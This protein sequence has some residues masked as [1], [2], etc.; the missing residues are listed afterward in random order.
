MDRSILK[1]KLFFIF[2]FLFGI[3]SFTQNQISLEKCDE[4]FLKNNLF[5]LAEQFN[6]SASKAEIIQA[7]IWDLPVITGELNAYNPQ[8]KQYFDVN[9]NGQKAFAIQ[10]LIYLGGKKRNE[11]DFA[12]S[13]SE[14]A[15]LQ[16]EQLLRNLKYQLHQSFYSIY[17]DISKTERINVQLTNLDSL[18]S[19]YTVQSEKGNIPLKDLVR[20]ESLALSFK[21]VIIDIQNNIFLEQEKLRILTNLGENIEPKLDEDKINSMLLKNIIQNENELKEISLAK[22]PDYLTSLKIIENG[23]LYVKWQKSL[24]IPDLTMGASYD[25]RGGAFVNQVNVTF[26]IP[27]PLWRKNKGNVLQATA[28]LEESK[29]LKDQSALEL[30]TKISTA[31]SSYKYEQVKYIEMLN[32]MKQFEVVYIGIL[33]NFQKRNISL[34]EFTDFMES[35]NSSIVIINEIKNHIILTGEKI[36]YLTNE[37]IF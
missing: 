8:G 32:H 11:I 21:N 31:V 29:L 34:I 9:G 23:E 4:L 33:E 22:N 17:F 7:K 5:L 12:K 30:S 3:K 35:Y 19:A 15:E 26:G 13:N 36:N 6:I 18:I 24:N 16:F 2:F 1:I 27:L 37:K 25:Q 20:L 10:Q 14:I 28:K